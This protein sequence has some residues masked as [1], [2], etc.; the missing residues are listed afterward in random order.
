MKP[1]ALIVLLAL[2]PCSAQTT[3]NRSLGQW[4]GRFWNSLPATSKVYWLIGFQEGFG[5][6]HSFGRSSVLNRAFPWTADAKTLDQRFKTQHDGD[7]DVVRDIDFYFA[8][9]L[10]LGEV[11]AAIDRF[12][13]EPENL[14]LPI[15]EA[16][17][18]FTAKVNGATQPA[19]DAKLAA[20]RERN[21]KGVDEEQKNKA[22]GKNP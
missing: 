19:I 20:Y 18:V 4:N 13:A 21:I 15:V 11:V 16:L 5:L 3:S 6:G 8:S 9:T 14:I 22:V 12:Y 1:F 7:G 10:S 17:E 2:F